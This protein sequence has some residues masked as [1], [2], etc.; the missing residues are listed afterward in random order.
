MSIAAYPATREKCAIGMCAWVRLNL[1]ISTSSNSNRVS[2]LLS[3]N[4]AVRVISRPDRVSLNSP[5]SVPILIVWGINW[6]KPVMICVVLKVWM[7]C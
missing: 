2:R 5:N 1:K 3:I 4:K 6:L 7:N